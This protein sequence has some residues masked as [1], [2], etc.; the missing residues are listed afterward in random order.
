MT[1]YMS[2]RAKLSALVAAVLTVA[3]GCRYA[4]V[5]RDEPFTFTE[6]ETVESA[7]RHGGECSLHVYSFEGMGKAHRNHSGSDVC[8]GWSIE[9]P[10]PSMG[11]GSDMLDAVRSRI[12]EIAFSNNY[13]GYDS[14]NPP[15]TLDAAKAA[16]KAE[17]RKRLDCRQMEAC[18]ADCD[19]MAC[20][21]ICSHWNF[22]VDAK[23]SLPF[24]VKGGEAWYARPVICITKDGY[25]NDGGNGCHSYFI[26]ETISLPD[27][28]RLGAEDYFAKDELW[29][30]AELAFEKML[31]QN[32]LSLDD[33]FD[34]ESTK[35]DVSDL[36][37][38][39]GRDGVT[40]TFPAYSVL[41]GCYGVLSSV[42]PWSEIEPYRKQK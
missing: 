2:A 31:E 38:T 13:W 6:R 8:G 41:P 15:K 28:K 23:V 29:A 12:I 22:V 42:V 5:G 1:P 26:C 33:T 10:E 16:Y 21:H 4:D 7:D 27:G 35:V 14:E 19:G 37:M 36:E 24:G 34:Q 18:S 9:W 32:K 25:A 39:V 3:A 30:V 20:E 40:W 17:L 11:L